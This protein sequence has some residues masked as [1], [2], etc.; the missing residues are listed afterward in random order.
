[1]FCAIALNIAGSAEV[2]KAFIALT[3]VC[4]TVTLWKTNETSRNTF[5]QA[6]PF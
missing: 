3:F 6:K 4:Q 5:E 1:M 2:E